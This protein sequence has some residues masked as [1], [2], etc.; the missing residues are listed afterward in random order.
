M[1][2]RTGNPEFELKDVA[3]LEASCASLDE[4]LKVMTERAALPA[5]VKPLGSRIIRI[6]VEDTGRE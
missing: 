6:T 3:I 4:I 2:Q 5:A 1:A